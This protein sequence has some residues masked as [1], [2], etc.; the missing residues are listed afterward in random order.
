MSGID[1]VVLIAGPVEEDI[2]Y[3]KINAV[4]HFLFGLREEIPNIVLVFTADTLYILAG[5]QKGERE[6]VVDCLGLS[7]G[8]K[9]REHQ[10]G[11]RVMEHW[12]R[13]L[14]AV[15]VLRAHFC[16]LRIYVLGGRWR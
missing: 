16:I 14:V 4:H 13:V 6:G 11:C 15:C 5:G 2:P 8:T 9:T 10:R 7:R 1:A 12:I 3:R